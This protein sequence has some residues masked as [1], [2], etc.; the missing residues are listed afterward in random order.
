MELGYDFKW[1]KPL[2]PFAHQVETFKFFLENH[3][4]LCANDIG[5]GKTLSALWAMDYL[6]G[7]ELVRKVLI[8][9]TLSTMETVWGEELRL[10]FPHLRYA[11][12]NGAKSRR[13]KL[14]QSDAQVFIINHDG[15]RVVEDAIEEMDPD[16]II[17]D[18]SA[19]FRNAST[20]RYKPM[21]MFAREEANRA[22]WLLSG[23]PTPRA[24]TDIWAQV[25]LYNPGNVPRWFSRFRDMVMTQINQFK[26]VPKPGWEQ[27][28]WE[29][30]QPA[31]RF[32]RD[33]CIDIPE[34]VYETIKVP[35]HK[36]QKELY[37]KLK[38]Q[39]MMELEGHTIT[40]LNEGVM[41]NKLLQI[42]CG[43]VYSV[44]G[45]S[46]EI[47]ADPKDDALREIISG[48]ESQ[49]LVFAPFK[50][51]QARLV[52]VCKEF[53]D[54]AV[55]NGDVSGSARRSIFDRFNA[56]ALRVIVAHPKAM[57]HGLTLV[58]HC[59]VIVWYAPVDDYEIF[60]Q[61]NGRITRPG[62]KHK[63]YVLSLTSSEIEESI[64]RR[65]RNKERVQGAL[66][67][68]IRGSRC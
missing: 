45:E 24:P 41:I 14:L 52:R 9:S 13:L 33:E 2:P 3:R 26:W 29:A 51:A 44:D 20:A 54:V 67:D 30:C 34:C 17:L 11:V 5:T 60:E 64:Y 7:R 22:L 53:G 19:V 47:P 39:C 18:E 10:S 50:S 37:D 28:V 46:V 12:L 63:Q 49:V 48:T 66:L 31:I 62:Q 65:L 23:S 68:M 38:L 21:H 8:I 4:C 27:I 58:D 1:R 57:A 40:A 25:R 42:T 32:T 6:I 59:N 15:V 43:A 16:I 56:G 35:M 61:A 55:I 36:R